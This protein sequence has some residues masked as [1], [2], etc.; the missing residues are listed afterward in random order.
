M[1]EEDDKDKSDKADKPEG[2]PTPT[3]GGFRA[4]TSQEDFDRAIAKRLRA[5]KAKYDD[6]IVKAGR[7]EEIEAKLG[8]PVEEALS[9][10]EQLERTATIANIRADYGITKED[11]EL[12]LT[13]GDKETLE[14]QAKRLADTIA[15][16]NQLN[17]NPGE[18]KNPRPE[19]TE[20]QKAVRQLF[21]SPK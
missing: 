20:E 1:P 3:A 4:I 13:G 2:T 10:A 9:E 12:F 14:A 16:N 7:L 17:R 6:A 11:S 15:A 8:K 18:G 5:E 19:A 21:G